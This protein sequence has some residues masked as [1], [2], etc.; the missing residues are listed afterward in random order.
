MI[1]SAANVVPVISRAS[2]EVAGSSTIIAQDDFEGGVSGGT[3]FTG[4]W[5]LHGKDASSCVISTADPRTGSSHLRFSFGPTVGVEDDQAQANRDF[6]SAVSRE[7]W[8]ECYI[9]FPVGWVHEV[10]SGTS[11]NKIIEIYGTYS[12]S[13]NVAL[14]IFP[15]AGT[16]AGSGPEVE[17]TIALAWSKAGA[18]LGEGGLPYYDFVTDSDKGNWIQLRG[19]FDLGSLSDTAEDGAAKVWKDGVLVFSHTGLDIHMV[20]GLKRFLEFSLM[21]WAESQFDAEQLIDMDGLV[22]HGSDP[23]W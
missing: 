8:F 16:T 21:G 20:G 2:V 15:N 17:S 19:W 12:S 5:T 9:R 23:G 3:G 13:D 4:D 11:H 10:K 7:I 1:V 22:F 6:G 14:Q 18:G